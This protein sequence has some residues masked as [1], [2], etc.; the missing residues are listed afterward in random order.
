MTFK[1][2]LRRKIA[3]ALQSADGSF[4][5]SI[6]IYWG[7]AELQD[8]RP[9]WKR[10]SLWVLSRME[11]EGIY[12]L[13]KAYG[14]YHTVCYTHPLCFYSFELSGVSVMDFSA[15]FL[16]GWL[17]RKPFPW[18]HGLMVGCPGEG[19]WATISLSLK[20][21]NMQACAVRFHCRVFY[22]YMYICV[23]E[24]LVGFGLCVISSEWLS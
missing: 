10:R 12:T 9:Q 17:S 21:I 7:T 1:K 15:L 18:G 23:G 6:A 16:W 20:S 22:V 19:I 24:G 2:Y 14:D 13:R 5:F 8:F 4:E 3:W 11:T